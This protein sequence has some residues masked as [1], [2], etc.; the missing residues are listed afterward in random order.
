MVTLDGKFV[1]PVGLVMFVL[2]C[3]V[4]D[5]FGCVFQ[6]DRSP[7]RVG[8]GDSGLR[9]GFCHAG[10]EENET[11][12]V[13][14]ADNAKKVAAHYKCMVRFMPYLFQCG[15]CGMVPSVPF[16]CCCI[17]YLF[18]CIIS[19]HL[20]SCLSLLVAFL[21]GNSPTHHHLTGWVWELWHQD[22]HPGN[23]TREKNGE[24]CITIYSCGYV[25]ECTV[26]GFKVIRL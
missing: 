7:L 11:R 24:N 1:D 19:R 25:L 14:H 20:L 12:G 23:K 15:M 8:P 21:I 9:C 13:L 3:T 10:E 4:W 2:L 18:T 17:S 5:V 26:W 22:G 6:R 16:C